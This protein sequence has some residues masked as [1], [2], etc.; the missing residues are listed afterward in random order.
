MRRLGCLALLLQACVAFGQEVQQQNPPPEFT[1]GYHPP[2][3]LAPLPRATLFSWIDVAVLVLVLGLGALAVMNKRSR[4]EIRILTIFSVAYFGFY[5]AGCV[6]S[7]G[8]LQNVAYA[9]THSDYALPPVVALF[10][11][12]PLVVALFVGRVFCGTACPFGALQDLV[13]IK[14]VKL[15][16]GLSA[17]LGVLP[18]AYLGAGVLFSV[19][20]TSFL[21]CQ[22]DPFVGFFRFS[23]P[24]LMISLGV[25]FL[26]VGTV[27]GRPFCRFLCPYGVLLR[28]AS[29]FASHGVRI[30]PASCIQCHMCADT[31]PYD[32]IRAPHEAGRESKV[33]RQAV[34]ILLVAPF[35]IG[36]MGFAGWRLAPSLA[37][38]D[39]RVGLA[40]ALMN[41]AR[42]PSTPKTG[43]SFGWAKRGEDPAKAY[44]EAAAVERQFAFGAPLLGAWLGLIV[45]LRA[46]K[47]G[48]MHHN[49]E[50]EA[51]REECFHCARCLSSCPVPANDRFGG[52]DNLLERQAR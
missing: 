11:A 2:S 40:R 19:T 17:A 14:P 49:K 3:V 44:V 10:F 27:V 35:I 31:C 52:L 7:V 25:G 5:R 39:S 32:A 26:L 9:A 33:R 50:Y 6:C 41:E 20:G 36:A 8:S 48:R 46:L 29:V 13:L 1:S 15:P 37:A 42:D 38:M 47:A 30:T 4:A 21:I 23:G 28:W 12:I 45:I 16:A 43:A 24:T 34:T 22:Y 18:Y 51:I